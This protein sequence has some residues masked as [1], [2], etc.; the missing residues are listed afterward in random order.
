M[1][2]DPLGMFLTEIRTVEHGH[3]GPKRTRKSCHAEGPGGPLE[4]RFG[5]PDELWSSRGKSEKLE[6]LPEVHG[7]VQKAPNRP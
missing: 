4:A 1:F 7:E 2:P 3:N 5:L 6:D